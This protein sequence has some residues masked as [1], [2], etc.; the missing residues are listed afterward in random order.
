MLNFL[1]NNNQTITRTN[2]FISAK[3]LKNN[4]RKNKILQIYFLKIPNTFSKQ[5]LC[6]VFS[7]TY[8]VA[9]HL[10]KIEYKFRLP[11]KNIFSHTGILNVNF[12]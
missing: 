12:F 11:K 9:I 4:T 2:D 5:T 6:S 8:S 1:N 10:F 3:I 7:G